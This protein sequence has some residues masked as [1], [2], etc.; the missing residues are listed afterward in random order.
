[1]GT[2]TRGR[3]KL[4]TTFSDCVP[5][6]IGPHVLRLDSGTVDE[7]PA[8]EFRKTD[9]LSNGEWLVRIRFPSCRLLRY[10]WLVLFDA[11]RTSEIIESR[12][13]FFF[14]TAL[15]LD[16]GVEFEHRHFDVTVEFGHPLV[17]SRL[18]EHVKKRLQIC[19]SATHALLHERRVY[20]PDFSSVSIQG[21][22][23]NPWIPWIRDPISFV[24]GKSV[25]KRGNS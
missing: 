24:R 3:V 20:L 6:R 2:T 23:L 21:V 11:E 22:S 13:R 14:I 17:G 16:Q 12:P 1:M 4:E 5:H 19:G 18:T 15:L 9:N 8:A 7:Q 10:R 25:G